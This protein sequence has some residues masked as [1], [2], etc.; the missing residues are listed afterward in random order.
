[1]VLARCIFRACV[2]PRAIKSTADHLVDEMFYGGTTALVRINAKYI[3]AKTHHFFLH[4][5][6]LSFALSISLFF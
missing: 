6:A 1:M 2:I 4:F 5:P 3:S